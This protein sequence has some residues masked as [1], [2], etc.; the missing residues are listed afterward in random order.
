MV[1]KYQMT[2]GHG[3]AEIP[4]LAGQASQL[5]RFKYLE[6]QGFS[7]S[8]LSEYSGDSYPAT[9]T[10]M[11]NI[12]RHLRNMNFTSPANA[13]TSPEKFGNAFIS[14]EMLGKHFHKS[15]QARQPLSCSQVRISSA[16]AF[17]YPDKPGKRFHKLGKARPRKAQPR[18]AQQMLPAHCPSLWAICLPPA[19][20][21]SSL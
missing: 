8:L 9:R 16:N 17:T 10:S 13:F 21:L 3:G 20:I 7:G 15:G 12:S 6:Q 5:D 18:K 1:Y 19:Q 11:T 14:P 4:W 2:I